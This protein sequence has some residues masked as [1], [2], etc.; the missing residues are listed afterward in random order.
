MVGAY[1]V[2]TATIVTWRPDMF[3]TSSKASD[4]FTGAALAAAIA[5]IWVVFTTDVVVS[6]VPWTIRDITWLDMLRALGG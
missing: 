3:T 2:L 6:S 5:L 4:L 1:Q